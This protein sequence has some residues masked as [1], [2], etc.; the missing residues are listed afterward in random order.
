MMDLS[1]RHNRTLAFFINL[2][3][4]C[5]LLS[6]THARAQESRQTTLP[7]PTG[8]VNDF[9]G[10]ID[11]SVKERIENML[12]N[13]KERGGIEFNIV[14]VKSTEGKDIFDYSLQF[15]RQW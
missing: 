3:L 9:A 4:A 14:T 13:L 1:K 10:V 11:A 2:I 6:G 8:R 15:A 12:A 7:S 5:S